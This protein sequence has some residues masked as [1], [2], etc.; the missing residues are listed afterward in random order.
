MKVTKTACPLD[1]WDQC[2][3]LIREENGR[4]VS[5]EP[6]SSQ[7]VTG[8]RICSKGK[9]HLERQDHPDRL[10]RPL[11]KSGGSFKTISWPAALHVMAERINAALEKFGPLSL[12]HYYDGG[13]SGLLKNLESR[14]FSALGGST[15]TIGSLCW[16]AGLAAQKYDFGSSVAHPYQDL[17][18][19]R[20][21]LIWGR[22]PAYTAIHLLPYIRKARDNGARVILIDPLETATA[23]LADD[24]IRIKPGSDGA[25]A[26][27]MARVIIEHGLADLDFIEDFSSG[28]E[29]FKAACA[30]YTPEKVE[31]LTGIRPGKIEELALDYA[32]N[33]PAAILIGIGLQRH[34]NGGNTVR[35]I[36][37]LAAITGNIGVA[38]GG[39]SYANFRVTRYIDHGF[40]GG[41]DLMPR[42]RHC[43]RPQ[44]ARSLTGL[45]EPPVDFLYISRA[46]P[47]VQVGD[48]RALS[49]AF[50]KVPFI[51]TVDHFMTDTAKASDL[52]LPC[53]GFLEETDLYFNSMSHQYMV[54]GLPAVRPPGECRPEYVFLKDLADLLGVQ[55]YPDSDPDRLLSRLI[56][57]LTESTGITLDDIKAGSPLLLPG[58]NE[59]PWADG[60][61]ETADGK[62]NFYSGA[63]VK[64]GGDGLPVYREPLELGSRSL[65]KE[66]FKYWFVTPHARDTIHSIHRLPGGEEKPEAY[67]SPETAEKEGITSGETIEI[68]SK[69]GSIKAVAVI[70]GRVP[71]STVMVYQ[72]W[73]QSS[74]AAVNNLTADCETDIG[75][76]AAYYD[77]LCRIE[78][79]RY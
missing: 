50:E 78:G 39:A 32:G 10:L 43:S 73:W 16:G 76:Q 77:C 22:N 74:G 2:A 61:F 53:T 6:D 48:S 49:H 21:L 23:G 5:V 11:L 47:L 9:R 45:Q 27:G 13:Y 28:F 40:L 31:E 8:N 35:A 12:F 26:L 15:K 18:N 44:L 55:G 1:C 70:S 37:A 54:Y 42:Q 79:I 3:L 57:P 75:N 30:D 46:N 60:R 52:V 4:L 7:P 69:R 65:R 58:G 64:D 25:L 20:Q 19:T 71:A 17:A 67:I 72:G 51:V 63:A 14:F 68:S 34:S 38:G 33:K 62:F 24:Y 66:G 59:V 41:K 36:D 56:L 29:K